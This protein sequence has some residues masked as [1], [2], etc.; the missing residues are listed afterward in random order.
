M[1]DIISATEA[2]DI[3]QGFIEPYYPWHRPVKAVRENGTWVVEFDVGAVKVE[4]ATVKIDTSS[5]EVKEF[6]KAPTEE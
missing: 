2:I 4:I 1:S 5:K 6:T 3:A